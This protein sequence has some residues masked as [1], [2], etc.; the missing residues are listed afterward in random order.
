V[1]IP[2]MKSALWRATGLSA[3]VSLGEFGATSFLSRSE[4]T[5]M[6]I[7][8]SQL[9]GTVGQAPQQ[10]AFALSATFMI[11]TIGVMSRA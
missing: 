7:A 10:A 6:P 2:V 3:A 1:E 8:I 5:T 4:S 11:V 9:M